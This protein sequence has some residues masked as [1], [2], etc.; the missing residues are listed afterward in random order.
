MEL[1]LEQLIS[2]DMLLE[3]LKPGVRFQYSV[4]PGML[5]KCAMNNAYGINEISRVGKGMST[6]LLSSRT[7]KPEVL[8]TISK[9]FR[10]FSMLYVKSGEGL[11][12][13]CS[14]L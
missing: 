13:R 2:R 8:K 6:V 5:L 9:A 1:R 12:Q 10:N 7:E 11:F 4:M 3:Y 14:I